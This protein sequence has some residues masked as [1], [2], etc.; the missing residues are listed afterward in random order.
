MKVTKI[1]V[2]MDGVIANFNKRYREL[3]DMEP[4]QAERD[5][6][7]DHYFK[8]F[9]EGKNF[10]TLELMPDAYLGITYLKRQTIPVEILSSTADEQKYDEISS[11]KLKWLKDMNIPWKANFVPGK[12]H[13]YKFATPGSVIIDD[14]LKVIDDWYNAGGIAIHHKNWIDTLNTLQLYIDAH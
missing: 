11:Q 1:Y 5:K 2:D 12:R 13:K 3:N 6:K 7:F 10:A 9:I 8:E 4:R 14:T